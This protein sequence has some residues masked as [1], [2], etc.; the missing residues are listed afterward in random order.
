ML[1]GRAIVSHLA[2]K[3]AISSSAVLYAPA[4]GLRQEDDLATVRDRL[5]QGA[6]VASRGP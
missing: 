2:S 6:P 5:E 3:A 4:N 1:Q